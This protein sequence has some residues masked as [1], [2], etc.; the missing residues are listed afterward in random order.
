MR[1]GGG[2]ER[3]AGREEVRRRCSLTEQRRRQIQTVLITEKDGHV[4]EEVK[5]KEQT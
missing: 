5:R 2:G 4:K 1:D 3:E